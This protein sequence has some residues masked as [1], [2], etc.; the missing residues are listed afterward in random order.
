MTGWEKHPNGAYTSGSMMVW[1]FRGWNVAASWTPTPDGP[2][3]DH[4]VLMDVPTMAAAKTLAEAH[5]A[6]RIRL[7][8]HASCD[9]DSRVVGSRSWGGYA[10]VKQCSWRCECGAGGDSDS[11]RDGLT[12]RVEHLLDLVGSEES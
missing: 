12:Q 6:G 2:F 4:V 5:A 9:T 8:D 3:A 7:D 11:K 10:A 1:R